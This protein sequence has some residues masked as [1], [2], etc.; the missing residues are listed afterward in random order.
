M[1]IQ[2]IYFCRYSECIFTRYANIFLNVLQIY[3]CKIFLCM[4]CAPQLKNLKSNTKLWINNPAVHLCTT[5]I[6]GNYLKV[7][8]LFKMVKRLHLHFAVFKKVASICSLSPSKL[9]VLYLVGA[10]EITVV[11][12]EKHCQFSGKKAETFN[13]L[14]LLKTTLHGFRK[15]SMFTE[16]EGNRIQ[17]KDNLADITYYRWA[18]NDSWS[19]EMS[20]QYIFSES[21]VALTDMLS[22]N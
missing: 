5:L 16:V 10:R 17:F 8:V 18:T 4:I 13:F 21:C 14:Q 7:I 3:F 12:G 9:P 11:V 22:A 15:L 6:I 19:P 2:Q 1:L 20:D